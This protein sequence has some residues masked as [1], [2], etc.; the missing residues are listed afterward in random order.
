[1][2]NTMI[3]ELQ[4]ILQHSQ[5]LTSFLAIS[6]ILGGLM[7]PYPSNHIAVATAYFFRKLNFLRTYIEPKLMKAVFE[8]CQKTYRL[9]STSRFHYACFL[10]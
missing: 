3:N 7:P 1:M 5:I 9:K 10:A 2:E 8:E 4:N 6:K